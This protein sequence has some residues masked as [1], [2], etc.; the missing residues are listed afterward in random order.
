NEKEKITAEQQTPPTA[1]EVES[2]VQKEEEKKK[3]RGCLFGCLGVVLILMVVV[4]GLGIWGFNN[5]HK[6]IPFVASRL[7]TKIEK[8]L[9]S[10]YGKEAYDLDLPEDQG[11]LKVSITKTTASQANQDFL[12]YYKSE[13]WTVTREMSE[14]PADLE[15]MA[16]FGELKGNIT[17]LEKD[18]RGLVI[19]AMGYN[20]ESTV[21]V[22]EVKDIEQLQEKINR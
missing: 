5:R 10:G 17:M 1:E 16:A 8:G 13:G 11:N 12:D 6:A 15:T 21:L 7:G 3:K 9:P 2:G 14:I 4:V 22:M 18:G 19:T 20:G